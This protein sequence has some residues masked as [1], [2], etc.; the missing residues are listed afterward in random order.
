MGEARGSSYESTNREAVETLV[1]V[2]GRIGVGSFLLMT[3]LHILSFESLTCD[4]CYCVAHSSLPNLCD[5][6]VQEASPDLPF[7]SSPPS[8]HSASQEISQWDLGA[9]RQQALVTVSDLSYLFTR[10]YHFCLLVEHIA[11]IVYILLYIQ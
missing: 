2:S 8:I 3:A 1:P 11:C 9:R 7:R 6:E 10:P 4:L 5:D